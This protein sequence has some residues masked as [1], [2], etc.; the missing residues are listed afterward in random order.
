MET[1]Q[2]ASELFGPLLRRR[3]EAAGL[4]QEALGARAGLSTAAISA[5]ERGE[6]R[7]PY[8]H[9]VR[10]LAD[11]LDLVAD[12]R[13][14]FIGAALIARAV[15]RRTTLLG[16]LAP[17]PLVPTPL[18]GRAADVTAIAG[19]LAGGE[20]LLTLTGTGGVGKTRL[21]L[22]AASEAM[23]AFTDGVAFVS[24]AALSDPAAL[25]R[26]IGAALG[27]R[28]ATLA[29]LEVA[30]HERRML[31]VLD[32]LEQLLPAAAPT[33]AA[34]SLG[35]PELTILATSR[36]PLR[37]RGER[38]WAVSPLALP[39]SDRARHAAEIAIF[40]A[41]QLFIALAGMVAPGFALT[42]TNAAVII[43]ICQRLD[44]LPL[45]LELAAAWTRLLR[46]AEL[47]ARL[48]RALPLLTGGARDLPARQRTL[49][50][51][52]AWSYD[53]LS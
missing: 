52:I 39:L 30:L 28:D 25:A 16:S 2:A 23:S 51:T 4:S 13:E 1:R 40:P 15:V 48:D 53:L 35:C 20:R 18:I 17:L 7:R 43:A 5:L 44:G 26:T 42:P 22:A 45:A 50:D 12:A 19:A 49:R 41:V 47:L 33:I 14:E 6:R 46:P 31:L 10:A 21:A 3:R 24:L 38:A 8:A 11:A 27:V 37:I 9:T 32:N 34:L 29:T 36:A